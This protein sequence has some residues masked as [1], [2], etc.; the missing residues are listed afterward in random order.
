MVLAY[1]DANPINGV[2]AVLSS[3]QT[4]IATFYL[5]TSLYNLACMHDLWFV[6]I[7]ALFELHNTY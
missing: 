6:N 2:L 5:L 3:N 4:N 7:V 1:F